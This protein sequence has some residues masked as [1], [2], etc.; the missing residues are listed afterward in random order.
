MKKYNN[1]S[2]VPEKYKWNLD[3]Y[4]KSYE[5]F[6]KDY[7][8]I[9]SRLKELDGYKGKLKDS[10]KLLEFIEKHIHLEDSPDTKININNDNDNYKK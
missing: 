4:Y 3:E 7:K 8:K 6:D 5:E 10:K 9:S 2:E 1:R